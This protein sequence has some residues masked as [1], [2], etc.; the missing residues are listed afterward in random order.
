MYEYVAKNYGRGKVDNF[1][2]KLTRGQSTVMSNFHDSCSYRI[3]QWA[4]FEI[5]FG[6]ELDWGIFGTSDIW[7]TAAHF[8]SK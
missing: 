1:L 6:F 7:S 3:G 4:I 8:L 5:T 2:H